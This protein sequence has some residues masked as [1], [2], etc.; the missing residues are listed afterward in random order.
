MRSLEVIMASFITF[1]AFVPSRAG[2]ATND[3]PVVR[4]ALLSVYQGR[5]PQ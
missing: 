3:D 2:G 4:E 1:V 5:E